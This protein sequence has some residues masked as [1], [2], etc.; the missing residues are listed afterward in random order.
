MNE[1]ELAEEVYKIEERI[2]Y[3]CKVRHENAEEDWQL[4]GVMKRDRNPHGK[5]VIHCMR[6]YPENYPVDQKE[7]DYLEVVEYESTR[8]VVASGWKSY[9]EEKKKKKRISSSKVSSR[10]G[11]KS[12]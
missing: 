4:I 6:N 7:D 5:V 9:G 11:S 2:S 3:T 8:A 12:V 10:W 1:K